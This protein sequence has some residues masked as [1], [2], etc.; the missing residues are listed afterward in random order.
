MVAVTIGVVYEIVLMLLV[1]GVENCAFP[2]ICGDALLLVAA[3]LACVDPL[4]GIVIK[5]N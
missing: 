5:K 4:L 3:E 1:G 2:H